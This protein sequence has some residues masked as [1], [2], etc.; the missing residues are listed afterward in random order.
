MKRWCTIFTTNTPSVH[1]GNTMTTPNNV[2]PSKKR[3]SVQFGDTLTRLLDDGHCPGTTLSAR[4]EVL[5]KR[6]LALID[7]PTPNWPLATWTNCIR[8]AR[9]VD[10]THPGAVFALAA[11]CKADKLDAKLVYTFES[12]PAAQGA[13]VISICE[14]FL[15]GNREATPEEVAEFLRTI[16]ISSD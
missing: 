15:A 11:T 10:L 3:T 4:L 2:N 7:A 12:M 16:G 13:A 5:A 1:Q 14:R 8:A 6:Y 9:K